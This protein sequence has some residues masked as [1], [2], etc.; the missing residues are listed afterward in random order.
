MTQSARTVLFALGALLSALSLA[1][2]APALVDLGYQ[3]RSA[4]AFFGSALLGLA[5]GGIMTLLGRSPEHRLT[6]RGAILLTSGAWAVLAFAA[7]LPLQLSG[8]DISWTD[9]I[10]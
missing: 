9:A 1:M 6:A 3:G 5:V 2:L 7:A 8:L 4:P 10:F